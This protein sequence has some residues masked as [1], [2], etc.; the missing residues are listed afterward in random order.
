MP[1][2][3]LPPR[4]HLITHEHREDMVSL[5]GAVNCNL[6]Q[7]ACLRVHGGCPELLGVHLTKTLVPLDGDS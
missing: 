1:L 2:N 7:R 4:R 5:G 3:E 6:A